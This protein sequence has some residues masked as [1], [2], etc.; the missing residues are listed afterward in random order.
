MNMFRVKLLKVFSNSAF[1]SFNNSLKSFSLI[2]NFCIILLYEL[3][4]NFNR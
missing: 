2:G 3:S 1:L 4:S